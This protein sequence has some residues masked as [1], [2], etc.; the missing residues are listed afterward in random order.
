MPGI[1]VTD[2]RNVEVIIA[3][4]AAS[5]GIAPKNIQNVFHF[6][7]T[8]NV[9]PLSKAN[10]AAAFQTAIGVPLIAC[11][12][13]R[14]TELEVSVRIQNDDTDQAT[15]FAFSVVGGVTGDSMA[16]EN[17]IY[18][19]LSTGFKGRSFRGNKKIG[20]LSEADTTT[21]GDILNAA[22]IARFATLLTAILTNFTDS[23]GNTWQPMIYSRLLDEFAVRPAVIA[24]PVIRG[25][26]NK[27]V[28]SINR[29]KTV[30][31]Y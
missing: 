10:V 25:A 9:N 7:R 13:A 8:T 30:S 6:Y 11:L 15:P 1:P 31:S 22:A 20:P 4:I 3:G 24:Y 27:R 19:K 2:Q 18:I 17:Q 5:A 16:V 12:N 26:V 29:R 14:Y 21:S 23:D 28:S